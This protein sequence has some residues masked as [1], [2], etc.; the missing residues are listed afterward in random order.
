MI[1]DALLEAIER[2]VERRHREVHRAVRSQLDLPSDLVAVVI[3]FV[4][5]REDEE[6]RAAFL[7][8]IDGAIRAMR[9]VSAVWSY[10][11]KL[12]IRRV[13]RVEK[14]GRSVRERTLRKARS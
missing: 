4:D 10:I 11:G 13:W 5:E 1:S 2:G 9:Q 12:Y 14:V 6:I 7:G 3:R 8:G